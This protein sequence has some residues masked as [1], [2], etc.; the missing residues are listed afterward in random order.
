[1]L[2][3]YA[4]SESRFLLNNIEK[5]NSFYIDLYYIRY[6]GLKIKKYIINIAENK[7]GF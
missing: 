4:R 3:G 2:L 7:Q 6:S 5:R 1:M